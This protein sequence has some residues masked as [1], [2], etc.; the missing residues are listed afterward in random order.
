MV[1]VYGH[2]EEEQLSVQG[3]PLENGLDQGGQSVEALPQIDRRG[4]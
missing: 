3:V 1:P 4:A 2:D